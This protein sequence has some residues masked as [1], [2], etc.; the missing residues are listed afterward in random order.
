[1][2]NRY[3][4]QSNGWKIK[5][6]TTQ[7]KKLLEKDTRTT[8]GVFLYHIEK[9][10]PKQRSLW[11]ILTKKYL[12]SSDRKRKKWETINLLALVER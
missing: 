6:I 10:A 3:E 2:E 12:I 8:A 4:A 9:S 7:W 5:E 11:L 1:M